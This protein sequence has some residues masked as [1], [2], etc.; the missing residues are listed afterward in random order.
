MSAAP[1]ISFELIAGDSGEL[2]A[3][4]VPGASLDAGA[5]I[6]QRLSALIS[7]LGLAEGCLVDDK[8]LIFCRERFAAARQPIPRGISL[9][10][11]ANH[12]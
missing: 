6:P 12:G 3:L 10:L 1:R 2:Q 8:S 4:R 7:R 5:A 11:F 9:F